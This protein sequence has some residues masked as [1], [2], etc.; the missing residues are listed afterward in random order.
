LE[1]KLYGL[2]VAW[3]LWFGGYSPCSSNWGPHGN[4][5]QLCDFTSPHSFL[6]MPYPDFCGG[7]LGTR[8]LHTYHQILYWFHEVYKIS[9]FFRCHFCQFWNHQTLSH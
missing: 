9:E 6:Q 4:N 7:R 5:C 8:L 2:M 1:G 3:H